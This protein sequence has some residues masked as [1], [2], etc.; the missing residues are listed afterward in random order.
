MADVPADPAL[1]TCDP[2]TDAITGSGLVIA[3]N[4]KSGATPGASNSLMKNHQW[5]FAPRIGIAWSPMS[6][7]TVRAGY[8]MYY[9]RGELFSYLSPS[10]GCRI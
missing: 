6:K 10:A 9:D 4:N 5:G 3:G 7:L 1:N 8:G 2:G